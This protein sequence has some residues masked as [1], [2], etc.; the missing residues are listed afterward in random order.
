MNLVE[1]HSVVTRFP[2]NAE[3]VPGAVVMAKDYSTG[4]SGE[5]DCY[6]Q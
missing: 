5:H 4:V 2:T 3:G 6:T 1:R